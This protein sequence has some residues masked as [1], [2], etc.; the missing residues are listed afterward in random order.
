MRER[1]PDVGAVRRRFAA[2]AAPP[3]A[4]A[5]SVDDREAEARA[6]AA[7]RLVGAAEAVEGARAG[8]RAGSRPL[9]RDVQLDVP[10]PSR[11]RRASTVPAP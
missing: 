11:A 10:S 2:P 9:V 7:A 8:T 6:A 5:I 3:C 4:A 1:E